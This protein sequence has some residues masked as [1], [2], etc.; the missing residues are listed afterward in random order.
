M[1]IAVDLGRK[2]I[3]RTNKQTKMF[4]IPLQSCSKR[5]RSA[6]ARQLTGP[7]DKVFTASKML[8]I[9]PGSNSAATTLGMFVT[10]P[11]FYGD[12]VDTTKN[13]VNTVFSSHS[14]IDKTKNLNVRW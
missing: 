5:K 13:T 7:D 12:F 2:A 1:T 10:E 4:L 3:K 8:H 14:K 6:G 9:L 11:I